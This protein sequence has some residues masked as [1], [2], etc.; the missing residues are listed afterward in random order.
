AWCDEIASW[1]YPEAW[2]MLMFGLRLGPDPRVVVTTTLKPI[3]G[4]ERGAEAG[5]C[6]GRQSAGDYRVGLGP[7]AAAAR[8]RRVE[9]RRGW[10]FAGRGWGTWAEGSHVAG[11]GR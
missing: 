7:G 5:L 9:A 3:K 10:F 2:D 4:L 8:T 1:R 6:P 11:V